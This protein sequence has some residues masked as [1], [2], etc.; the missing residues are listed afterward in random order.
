MEKKF[1]T[2]I[3]FFPCV[4]KNN[5]PYNGITVV[6]SLSNV[7]KK[8]VNE[9][10]LVT[11]RGAINNRT[12][13]INQTLGTAFPETDETVWVDVNFWEDRA[14]RFVKFLGDR[15]K[16]LVCIMGTARGRTFKKA[17]E[18]DGY[19]MTIN[20]DDWFVMNGAGSAPKGPEASV[21]TVNDDDLP[22]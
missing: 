1:Y 2:N 16:V 6:L 20:A 10:N 22:Y 12:K 14:D 19:A 9:K 17:D 13:L 18:T 7:Q 21:P 15:E 3:K 8:T 4:D 5:A 11:A